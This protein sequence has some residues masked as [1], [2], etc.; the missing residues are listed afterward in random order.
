VLSVLSAGTGGTIDLNDLGVKNVSGIL[1]SLSRKA[2]AAV[3]YNDLATEVLS[4]F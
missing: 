4:F 2:D 3:T 1:S